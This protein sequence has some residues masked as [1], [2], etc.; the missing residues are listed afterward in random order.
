GGL[1]FSP[2]SSKE[3]GKALINRQLK[4][5]EIRMAFFIKSLFADLMP[6][7]YE[8]HSTTQEKRSAKPLA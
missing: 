4:L 7:S 3:K 1:D 2:F 8:L 6:C 5:G